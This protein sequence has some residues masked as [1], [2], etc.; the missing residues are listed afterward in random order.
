MIE[1]KRIDLHNHLDG[2]LP[3]ATILELAQMSGVTLP[4]DTVE[5]ITKYLT[6]SHDCTSLNEYLEKFDIPVSVLQTEACLEKAVYDLMQDLAQRGVCYAELRFAPGQHRQRGLSQMAVTRA[7]LSGLNKAVT[8]LPIRGRLILCCMRGAPDDVNRETIDVTKHFLGKGVCCADLA[9]AEAIFPTSDYKTLFSYAAEQ[10]VPYIIH[11][12]EAD[13][14]DSMWA[15]LEMGAVRIGHGIAAVQD[16]KLMEYLK[17]HRIPLEVCVTSNVQTKGAASVE[18]HPI[19]DMLEYGLAVTVNTD[20]MTVSGTDLDREFA[21]LRSRSGMTEEQ[22]RK[23][24]EN[25][26][27]AAF[28]SEEEKSNLM[29]LIFE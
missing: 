11:A 24:T 29:K 18:A 14:P 21:L 20:N 1:L 28:L 4:A 15:A 8:E 26:V 27:R 10:G 25:A 23:M 22:E 12:G 9:G 17:A 19:L 16:E 2:S 6:V 3:P 13:G 7:A 5:D